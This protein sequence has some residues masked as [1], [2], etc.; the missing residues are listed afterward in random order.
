MATLSTLP[1]DADNI[2]MRDAFSL[3]AN[4]NTSFFLTGKAG[5]GKT[6]FIR[7]AL[8]NI[9]KKFVI[10]APTGIAALSAGGQTIHHFF[11][12]PLGVLGNNDFGYINRENLKLLHEGV[13]TIIID[14]VSMVRCDVMDAIDRTLRRALQTTAPFGGIQMVFIGDLFQLEPVVTEKDRPILRELYETEEFHFF[15]AWSIDRHSIPKIELNRMYRQQDNWFIDLLGRVRE[16]HQTASDMEAL[17]SRTENSRSDSD[18]QITLTSFNRDADAINSGH[19]AELPGEEYLFRARYEGDC[20]S[21]AGAVDETVRLKAGAHVMFLKND[22]EYRWANGTMGVVTDISDTEVL[23]RMEN[24]E[25]VT[26][27]QIKWPIVRQEYDKKSR[28][29]KNVEIGAIYQIPLRLA[30][31]VTIHKSQSMTFSNIS[32]D[33]GRGA[34]CCGQAYVALSRAKSFDGLH[35]N[36]PLSNASIMVS[37]E[38]SEFS[39]N[40]NNRVLV[41]RE[42]E[43]ARLADDSVKRMDFDTASQTLL[44]H[45]VLAGRSGDCG[46]ALELMARFF[47][48]VIDDRHI[49]PFFACEGQPEELRKEPEFMAAMHL[50]GGRPDLSLEIIEKALEETLNLSY[51]RLRCYEEMNRWEDFNDLSSDLLIELSDW[52]NSNLPTRDFQKILFT[53]A[54]NWSH[55][56]LRHAVKGIFALMEDVYMYKPVYYLVREIA[57]SE[58]RLWHILDSKFNAMTCSD[59]KQFAAFIDAQTVPERWALRL[60]PFLFSNPFE[61]LFEGLFEFEQELDKE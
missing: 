61:K 27:G 35:L 43:I 56:N 58:I 2:P 6:T 16:G 10:L 37:R 12:L 30:W 15:N 48:I 38:V 18:Y 29:T 9:G 53:V 39:S 4:T 14:E 21:L 19:L 23:V 44:E 57:M 46:Q 31:A 1:I 32:V 11:G 17:N 41:E 33:F 13:D 55:I 25:S 47:H 52:L 28:R 40:V 3:L 60:N 22:D 54:R 5:T 7:N 20:A 49:K 50:Y 8:A 59:E 42:L 34:F 26:V 51:L 24:G 36:R 45:A